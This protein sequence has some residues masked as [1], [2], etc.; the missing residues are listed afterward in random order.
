VTRARRAWPAVRQAYLVAARDALDLQRPDSAGRGRRL[1]A[2]L[3]RLALEL[4]G[5]R[6]RTSAGLPFQHPGLG[7]DLPERLPRAPS[8]GERPL[9]VVRGS[10]ARSSGAVVSAA[11][12]AAERARHATSTFM[13]A[14]WRATGAARRRD[15]TRALKI[16]RG[17][18]GSPAA[19]AGGRTGTA[20]FGANDRLAQL[21]RRLPFEVTEGAVTLA[22]E[23]NPL[24]A[25]GRSRVAGGEA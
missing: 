17:R 10:C 5:T 15:L 1:K 8:A 3:D 22:S 14:S 7:A 12:G 2:A 16:A 23:P 11:A 19:V 6:R 21:A 13:Q 24:T 25:S 20:A 9:L 18:R 4:R